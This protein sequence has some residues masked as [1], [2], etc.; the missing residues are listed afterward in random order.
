MKKFD[1]ENK[2]HKELKGG[3]KML[4]HAARLDKMADNN[5]DL[6]KAIQQRCVA[7]I[8]RGYYKEMFN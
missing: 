2:W 3:V 4:E 7:D 1:Y 6:E 5:T 8:L